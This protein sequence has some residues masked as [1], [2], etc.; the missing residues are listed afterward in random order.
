MTR[1]LPKI[2]GALAFAGAMAI[3]TAAPSM[4]QGVYSRVRA[5]KSTSAR[6]GITATTTTITGPAITATGGTTTT[7]GTEW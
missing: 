5:S 2:I 3:G 1:N 4:A 7:T 6:A